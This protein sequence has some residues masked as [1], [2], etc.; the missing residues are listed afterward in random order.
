MPLGKSCQSTKTVRPRKKLLL[1]KV[2]STH[3][4]QNMAGPGKGTD[5]EIVDPMLTEYFDFFSNNLCQDV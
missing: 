4:S 2:Q 3:F 1:L 5:Q